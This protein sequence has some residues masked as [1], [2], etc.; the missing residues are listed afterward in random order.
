MIIQ[1]R[2]DMRSVVRGIQLCAD[3]FLVVGIVLFESH[4]DLCLQDSFITPI[5]LVDIRFA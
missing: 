2:P 4:D 3:L 5:C 1:N